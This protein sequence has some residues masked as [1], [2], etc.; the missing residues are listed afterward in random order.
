MFIFLSNAKTAFFEHQ[1]YKQDKEKNSGSHHA[2]TNK[3]VHLQAN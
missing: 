1:I 2:Y 3:F